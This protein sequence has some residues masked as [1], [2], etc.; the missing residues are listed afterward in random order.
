[1]TAARKAGIFSSS[2]VRPAAAA[3]P[4]QRSRRS[5]QAESAA[6]RLKPSGARPLPRPS[7]FSVEMTMT[8]RLKRSIRRLATMP[9]TPGCQPSPATTST[10]SC[11]RAGS[12]C[13]AASAAEA[14]C[15]S[16]CWRWVLISSR[17]AAMPAAWSSF[18]H[19]SSLRSTAALSMRP[20]ALRR[21]ARP[22]LTVSAVTGRCAYPAVSS[23][24]CRPGRIVSCKM[25]RPSCTMVR[26]S[27]CS[28]IMSAMVPSAASSPN[29]SSRSPGA[30][31][32]SAAQSLNATPAPHRLLQ[33]LSSSARLGSTTAAARG[34][35]SPGRWWSV[36][37]RS[38]PSSAAQSA[39]ATAVMPLSTVMTS[40]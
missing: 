10:R 12:A 7:P 36:M 18:S 33:G 17:R 16:V 25:A 31:S 34:S 9:M 24:A 27:P 1:M 32:S 30:Q 21:G 4:P 6:C 28:G 37:T 20:A 13:R 8:G 15:C 40:L 19:K 5:P 22:K 35:V 11:R 14:I 3:W 39:S 29:I 26:F 38:R 23:S 2:M